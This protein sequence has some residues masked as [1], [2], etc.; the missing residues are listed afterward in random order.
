MTDSFIVFDTETTGLPAKYLRATADNFHNWDSCRMV[1]IAWEIYDSTSHDEP[2]SSACYTIAPDNFTIPATASNIHD[3]T[4]EI[5]LSNGRSVVD[6][7]RVLLSDIQRNNVKIAVA[8]NV[9]FD[10]NVVL[11][12]IYRVNNQLN[13]CETT[14]QSLQ[15]YCTMIQGTP[16]GGRWPKLSQLYIKLIG[17]LPETLTLHRAD[18]DTRLCSAIY[19]MQQS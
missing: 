2:V 8:H 12:E 4:T 11:S 17:P 15:K 7:L 5:A 10:D 1:Q 9:A 13:N 18:E 3:I 14:W 16:R 6:V 19:K